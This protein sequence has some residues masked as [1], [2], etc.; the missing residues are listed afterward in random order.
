[1][2]VNRLWQ[3]HFGRGLVATPNDFGVQ[4]EKPTH[5]ELLDY[6]ATELI[7]SGWRLKAIHRLIMTSSVYMQDNAWDEARNAVDPDN[8]LLWRRGPQRLEAEVI[9]DSMLAVSGKLDETMYGAGTLDEGMN[10]RSIYFFVK[11]SK[12]IPLML[13]FDAPNAL[14][15]MGSR[16]TTT[17]APQA[18]ALMNNPQVQRYANAFSARLAGKAPDE[19]VRAAYEMAFCREPRA[20]ELADA[21]AFLRDQT[22]QYHSAGRADADDSAMQDFCQALLSLNEFVYVD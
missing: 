10:R 13:L 14:T 9:R 16:A 7:K 12:I 6:L 19:A 21:A 15:G 2:I 1:V 5:P 20:E 18:L 4:G 8:L 17:V 3:H 22:A 11:R